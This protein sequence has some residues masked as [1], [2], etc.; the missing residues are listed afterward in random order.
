MRQE[1]D[2]WEEKLN[3]PNQV[4]AV[5]S[6][7]LF[8]L[9][10]FSLYQFSHVFFLPFLLLFFSSNV[11]FNLL[12][13]FSSLFYLGFFQSPSLLSFSSFCFIFF[14]HYSFL[15]SILFSLLFI[16]LSCFLSVF[17]FVIFSCSFF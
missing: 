16:F 5:F 6:S 2:N 9:F 14:S 8:L 3:K 17:I 1:G 13:F 7:S 11:S 15:S 4:Y 12:I 10:Y